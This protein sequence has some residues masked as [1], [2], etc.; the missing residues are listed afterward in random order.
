MGKV[1]LLESHFAEGHL[2]SFHLPSYP[3]IAPHPSDSA[4]KNIIVLATE[5]YPL[6]PQSEIMANLAFGFH[7]AALLTT[8]RAQVGSKDRAFSQQPAQLTTD[9]QEFV[10]VQPVALLGDNFVQHASAS[11]GFE[12]KPNAEPMPLR[13]KAGLMAARRVATLSNHMSCNTHLTE[14]SD[15]YGCFIGQASVS[16]PRSVSLS[17]SLVPDGITLEPASF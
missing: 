13:G 16:G 7:A 8:H 12:L 5:L 2:L 9:G 6:L 14:V 4:R 1:V 10:R 3:S 17:V 11:A 15:S